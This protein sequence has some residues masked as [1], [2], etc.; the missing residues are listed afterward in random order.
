MEPDGTGEL[1]VNL[2][3]DELGRMIANACR[4]FGQHIT[5]LWFLVS[6]N[7]KIGDVVPKRQADNKRIYEAWPFTE[8][9]RECLPC[10]CPCRHPALLGQ[11]D[12]G[13]ALWTPAMRGKES[14]SREVEPPATEK[15][16]ERTGESITWMIAMQ[17]T[18]K[19]LKKQN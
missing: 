4:Y 7:G 12:M 5:F 14:T 11:C 15:N 10:R 6:T 2:L 18:H 13:H 8:A 9:P 19:S 17:V 1:P 3:A 16:G